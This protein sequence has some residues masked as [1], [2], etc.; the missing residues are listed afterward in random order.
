[1][2][3]KVLQTADWHIGS[4]RGPE[5]DGVNLRSI[6]TLKCLDELVR[7][8]KE[9][10][11][12]LV[13]VSGDIF[14]KAEIWQGRSHK[15]VLQARRVILSLAEASGLVV[16]MRGTPNHDSAE[17]FE[18]LQ[19]HFEFADNVEIVATPKVIQT[20][21]FD[22]AV[23]PGF[24][25]GVFRAKLPGLSKEEE[26]EAFTDELANIVLGLKAQCGSNKKAVLMSHYTVPGCNTE[27]GQEMLLT[28]FE[29]VLPSEALQAAA[30]DLVALGHIH[31]PQLVP[32]ISNCFYS[33][34]INAMN[35]N[36]EGQERGFWIHDY[37]ED[38]SS[39][40][41]LSYKGS[42]FF[43]TPYREFITFHF[44]DT[45]IATI[46]LGN[47]DEVALNYWRYSG[48]LI[49]KIVRIIYRCSYENSK[50][51]NK[52]ALEK[53]L[54]EDGAF[55]VWE[56]LPENVGTSADRS[57]MSSQADPEENLREYLEKRQHPEERIQELILK[58]RPVIAEAEAGISM[59]AA[60]GI[61]EPVEI[62]VKNYRN[63]E[64]ERFS[65][66]VSLKTL[67]GR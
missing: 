26:N 61:F 22:I 64:K 28:Q 44:T 34:A 56:I 52:A 24:D 37:G 5:E 50:A 30:F 55:M 2:D 45:D 60:T 15:E 7:I 41:G 1:M 33:G 11:P 47:Y 58:A 18:E 35:F 31:R 67:W 32:N 43:K 20:D 13:L 29:P 21:T 59:S 65:F 48:A 53:R 36:D 14:H 39:T 27:S 66:R 38:V 54:L 42:R 46:N 49:G 16:V 51:L 63:Y 12:D 40:G 17:A 10:E 4:F 9:E 57:N 19:A 23:L 3:Y 6:D 8:A 62:E 25:R